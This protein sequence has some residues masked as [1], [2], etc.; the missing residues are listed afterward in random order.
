M[1]GDKVQ[2]E[3]DKKKYINNIKK[4]INN[5]KLKGLIIDFRKHHGGNM[6]PLI[7]AF[8]KFF[9]NT[10][11]FAWSKR[12]I[13][14]TDNNW[15]NMKNYKLEWDKPFLKNDINTNIPIAIIIGK[16]TFSSGEIVASCFIN[17]KNVKFFGSNS[18]GGLSINKGYDIDGYQLQLTVE[19]QT[20]KDGK[21]QEYIEPDIYTKTPIKDAKKWIYNF[22]NSHIDT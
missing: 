14:K 17:S 9:N 7:K 1:Y 18:G 21:F 19:L 20:N 13:K 4:F 6:H 12:K 15:V 2:Y 3:K 8:D 16:N 11:L 22:I 5:K 10:T